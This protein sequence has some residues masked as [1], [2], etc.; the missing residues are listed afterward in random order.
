MA[1]NNKQIAFID[2]YFVNGFNGTKAYLSVYKG[3]TDE[4]AQRNA[5]K[6]LSNAQV[7]VEVERRQAENKAKYEISKDEIVEITKR[8]MIDNEKSAPPFALKAAEILIKMAGLNAAE[9]HDHT[10]RTEQPLFGD[11]KEND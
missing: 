3:V 6:S 10:V 11:N 1:L 9:K 4:T 7:K 2:E 8:I 5:S